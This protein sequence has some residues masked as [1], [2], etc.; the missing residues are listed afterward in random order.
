VTAPLGEA[1]LLET[2]LLAIV[3]HQSS[4][5]SKAARIVAAAGG[6]TVM[7]FG[8]RRAHGAEAAR[9]SAR[10]A[11]IAGCDS[12][13]FVEAGREFG[14]PLSGT[15]AH[16]WVQASA[17]ELAAFTRFME[18]YGPSSTLLL[19]TYDTA[20]AAKTIVSAGLRPA[21]VRI[22]SGDLLALSR[23][24]RAIFDAGGLGETK[25]LVSGELDEYRIRDLVA[26]GA[27]I[28]GFGV[29]TAL[30]TS[31]DAPALG[32][33]YKMVQIQDGSRLRDVIKRSAGKATWPGLKQVYRVTSSGI[34]TRD[35]IALEGEAC[36]G[37]PLLEPVIEHGRRVGA[38]APIATL[39]SRALSSISELPPSLRQLDPAGPYEASVSPGLTELQSSLQI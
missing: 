4:I 31:E 9:Y 30:S 39:R 33:V 37:R 18:T 32:G 6:R 11:Y 26:E 34:A 17:S 28:D 16:S 7:E 5:A 35:V 13:S 22:D 10:A 2:A 25:I 27:P 12:T 15:M 36:D 24:V 14:I 29:G 8:G 20:A 19:D 3:N 1:Q 23:Q 21:A 38:A